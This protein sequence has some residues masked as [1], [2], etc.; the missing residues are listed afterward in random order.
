VRTTVHSNEGKDKEG[1]SLRF[2]RRIGEKSAEPRPM[3]IG[4]ETEEEKRHILARA[5]NLQGTQ[6]QDISVVPDLTKKQRAK[7]A[8]MKQE[9]E[10]R[11]KSLTTEEC[12][13]NEKWLVVGR[14]GEKRLIK[15]IERDIQITGS[16]APRTE[17]R[18]VNVER[19]QQ[20]L[21][22]AP[23]RGPFAPRQQDQLNSQDGRQE[24]QG[25]W[26]RKERD[27]NNETGA[28]KKDTYG[29]RN[30]NGGEKDKQ[31]YSR[32]TRWEKDTDRWTQPAARN[33]LSSK[34]GRGSASSEDENQDRQRTRRF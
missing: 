18:I 12:N 21:P 8:K 28:R 3:V 7:E 5:R 2:C 26:Y 6:F 10:E 4:L 32:R 15:G 1:R 23:P 9:A 34:R 20:L 16:R 25:R 30:S 24:D 22:S 31:D 33:R 29:Q 27:N 13:R 19:G 17:S 14:R 11:N